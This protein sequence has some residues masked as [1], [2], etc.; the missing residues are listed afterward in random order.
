MNEGDSILEEG[1]SGKESVFMS[2]E[3][4][5]DGA[6]CLNGDGIDSILVTVELLP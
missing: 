5:G 3:R 6:L 1:N 2:S 4:A